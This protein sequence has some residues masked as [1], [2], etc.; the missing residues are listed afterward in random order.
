MTNWRP[1]LEALLSEEL[2]SRLWLLLVQESSHQTEYGT[3]L[4]SLF[5]LQ[6]F[7]SILDDMD[8]SPETI[9]QD[10]L[11]RITPPAKEA[12]AKLVEGPA[13]KEDQLSEMGEHVL[14]SFLGEERQ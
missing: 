12:A 11:A 8:T 9:E 5:G 13:P 10:L 4:K 3:K 7:V 2:E 6:R 1:S 14:R